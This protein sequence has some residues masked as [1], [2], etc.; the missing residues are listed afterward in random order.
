MACGVKILQ[1]ERVVCNLFNRRGVERD[2]MN[3]EFDNKN[4]P[5]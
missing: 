4:N 2:C 5:I 1:I 3:F